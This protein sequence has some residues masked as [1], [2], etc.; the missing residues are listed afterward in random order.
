M[1]IRFTNLTPT[2]R[3]VIEFETPGLAKPQKFT[4]IFRR[5]TDKR[6]KEISAAVTEAASGESDEPLDGV[7]LMFEV[8]EGWDAKDD[9]TG[10]DVPF[11]RETVA[12]IANAIPALPGAVI[13]V[14][15]ESNYRA[16]VKN[17]KAQ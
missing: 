11:D 12:T 2:Y 8:M 15:I 10:K 6:I 5:L 7:E 16:K 3:E 13:R 4:A 1:A 17:S 14:F 9:E